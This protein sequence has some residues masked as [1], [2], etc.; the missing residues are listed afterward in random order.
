MDRSAAENARQ[1]TR[2]GE[3]FASDAG[4]RRLALDGRMI[5]Y[6]FERRRRRTIGL[7]VDA[8]G[9][10]VSAP[11]RATWREIEAFLRSSERWIVAKLAEWGRAGRRARLLGASG[12]TLPLFGEP[13]VLQVR[14]GARE[15]LR[16]GRQLLV[17]HPEPTRPGAVRELLV[18]WL[19]ASTLEA[20]APRAAHYAAQLGRQAPPIAV[21]NARSQWG[22][23]REDG[24]LRLSWRL[25]HLAP[26]LADYVVAHEVAHLVELNHSK[27]FWR[28][29]E[30][31]YPDWRAA[32][33]AIEV[34]GA[35][36]PIL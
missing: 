28:V 21:S 16:E 1:L 9:L 30:A 3:P 31:L 20:L 4:R 10:A 35:A 26:P 22:V 6:R 8:D 13:A 33:T 17:S 5:E 29:V 36:L 27:R 24:R 2:F 11:H 14:Q 19:K 7:R 12:E 23:C 34:A 15:V 25:V 32:R 18:R